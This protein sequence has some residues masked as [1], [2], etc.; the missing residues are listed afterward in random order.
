MIYQHYQTNIEQA[1]REIQR[2]NKAVNQ[3]SFARLFVILGGGALLFYTFSSNSVLLVIGVILAIVLLFAYLVRRQSLLEKQRDHQQAYLL[4]NENEI[5][6]K[7]QRNTMYDDGGKFEDGRHPY[8]ADLDIFGQF[9]LFS[10]VNRC[11]TKLGVDILAGWFQKAAPKETIR[12]RQAAV[13]ELAEDI[14]WSQ[15]FQSKLV[16]NLQ[17]QTEVKSY[18]AR[19]FRGSGLTFGNAA[20]KYYVQAAPFLLLAAVLFS[21]LVFP[22]WSWIAMLALAHLC[23]TLAMAGKVSHFSSKIDKVGQMLAAYAEGLVLIED[24]KFTAAENIRLQ[25]QLFIADRPLSDAFRELSKLINNLD[26]RN[27]MLVGAVLNMI[28]LWDFKYVLKI[29]RWKSLYEENILIAFDII[30]SF[31]SLNSLAILKR[32]HPSWATPAIAEDPL[33]DSLTAQEI[34]HPLIAAGLPVSNSYSNEDHDIALITGSNMAGKSTFLRTIGINAVLA[35]AGGVVCAK[36]FQLP[37]YRLIS[38]MRIKDSLNESTSTFKAELDRMKFILDTVERHPDSFFLIDE[39][40]RGTNSVDKYLGSRAIIRKLLQMEGRGMVATHDLQLASLE[41]ENPGKLRNFHFDIQVVEGEMLFDY[42]LKE[43]RCTI[44]NASLL[45]K[46]IGVDVE[47][48]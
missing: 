28:F 27:N 47:T 13:A 18:L 3:N 32:N 23:W 22:I 44:F 30:A 11:A 5:Q 20:M 48:T 33:A 38:Y 16:F 34:V 37:I 21:L 9:S 6:L 29:V 25:K 41:E 14:H 1:Q 45:L 17:Q 26:A 35:Y 46:G 10:L 24:R 8:S 2:L 4:I 40:L 7:E 15:A 36:V 39:M 31:E 42:K 43:G 19:Y 12:R